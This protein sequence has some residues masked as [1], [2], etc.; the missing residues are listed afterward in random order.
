MKPE[1]RDFL[2]LIKA[3][4]FVNPFAEKRKRIDEQALEISGG[5][6]E[7]QKNVLTNLV[8][9]VALCLEAIEKRKGARRSSLSAEDKDLRDY[10]HLF[11]LFHHFCDQ[12][13]QHIHAQVKEKEQCLVVDFADDLLHM[14]NAR[15]FSVADSER[16]FALFFQLRR[17]FYFISRI[18]GG[19]QSMCE[20]RARL[21]N[22]VFSNN[23]SLY[24][25]RLWNRMED[26]STLLLG[27]TGAG[28][29]MAAAAIGRSGYIP[30]LAKTSRFSESF[31]GAFTPINLCQYSQELIE[32]ELF[33]HRKGAFTGALD[34]HQG[35]LSRCS[36]CG[37]IFLDEIG[38]VSET[39]QI[40]LLKVLEDRN[41]TPVGSQRQER[42]SGR[43]IAATNRNLDNLRRSGRFRDD[44]YYR[45]CSNVIV[46]PPLRKRLQDDPGE[47]KQLLQ[48]VVERI[49]GQ[50]EYTI[51]AP[52]IAELGEHFQQRQPPAYQWPGNI[53][54]LEQR[55]RQ[56]LLHGCCDWSP[57]SPERQTAAE[58]LIA[59]I[60]AGSL[61]CKNLQQQ[62]CRLLYIQLKTYEAVAR[63][64]GLDRRT[65]K[66]YIDGQ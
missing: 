13:D 38:E 33:G 50:E 16:F 34:T 26:F 62:Y 54:E 7:G 5:R 40:K 3:A 39:V 59:K 9:R 53:R 23:I 45:L 66:K 47:I 21:W 1:Q 12:Y 49:L 65:V 19:S 48:V 56:Y 4:A 44:F 46:I 24:R 51:A 6:L 29:G 28:K 63:R 61:T 55:A 36:P 57:P 22:T 2:R 15:G 30:F 64:T 35:V 8:H 32:S 42:F 43:V 31:V 17:A 41:F 58:Q 14:L 20:F 10:G 52:L 18:V 37:S 11:Y 25:Q 27:E 60:E